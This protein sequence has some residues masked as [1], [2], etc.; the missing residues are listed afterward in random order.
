VLLHYQLLP[1]DERFLALRPWECRWLY[2][3]NHYRNKV[4]QAARVAQDGKVDIEQV[5]AEDS[6]LSDDDF[7]AE[8]ARRDAEDTARKLGMPLPEIPKPETI[9]ED[10]TI[11]SFTAGAPWMSPDL[12]RLKPRNG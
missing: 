4:A 9:A 8:V 10:E 7:D 2:W 1:T 5:L 12:V 3:L 11:A 6:I